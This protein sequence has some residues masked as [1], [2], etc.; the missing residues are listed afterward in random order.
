MK[1]EKRYTVY[2]H[3][4]KI[5][6][7]SYVGVTSKPVKERWGNNGYKYKRNQHFWNAICKY[8]WDNFDH[9]VLFTNLSKKRACKIE[10]L[11]ITVFM[12]QDP[13]MGYNIASGGEVNAGFHL[14][15]EVKKRLSETHKGI[16]DGENNPMYGVSP[17]ERMDEETYNNWKKSIQDR[18]ISEENKEKL[19]QVNIG[20][21]Y[22]D[23]VNAKKGHKGEAHPNYGKA[24][25]DEIKE[26]L[27][28]ANTGRKYSDEI[29]KQKGHK[30]ALNPSAR[31]VC[32]FTK[33]GTLVRQWSYAKLA[34][35]TLGINLSSIIACC[36]GT[37]GRKSAGGYLWKYTCD[38][39]VAI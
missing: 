34:S 16:F 29:N 21:K 22:S 35:E 33:D 7:K 36:R 2:M 32:Q 30:G 17:R 31:S 5:N 18:M 1:Q 15:D 3:T 12:T 23:E 26:K 20:K 14:S 25:S 6:N 8:G 27:R 10:K 28:Q 11:L 19:R 9:D 13:E 38:V 39:E 4:N 37:N 24:I